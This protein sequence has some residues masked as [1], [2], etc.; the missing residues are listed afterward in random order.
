M[1]WKTSEKTHVD[2][3]WMH[4]S[5]QCPS[6]NIQI[7]RDLACQEPTCSAPIAFDKFILSSV[8]SMQLPLIDT[9]ETDHLYEVLN[10]CHNAAP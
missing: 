8:W 7:P 10:D 3:M 2:S 9:N 1:L 6:K 5:A 4:Q